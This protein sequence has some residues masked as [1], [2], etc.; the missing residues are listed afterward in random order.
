MCVLSYVL[1]YGPSPLH[2]VWHNFHGRH[3]ETSYNKKGLLQGQMD[4]PLNETGLQQARDISIHLLPDT[5]IAV[6][7]LQRAVVTATI[8]FNRNNT[9]DT[10]GRAARG[11]STQRRMVLLPGLMERF[12]GSLQGSPINNLRDPQNKKPEMAATLLLAK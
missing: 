10:V 4:I 12:I 2:V 3:G 5:P 7:P 9:P 11:P 1:S 6:S 8:A